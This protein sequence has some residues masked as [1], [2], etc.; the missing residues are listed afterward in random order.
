MEYADWLGYIASGL[1]AI[2]MMMS[3]ILKFRLINLAGGLCFSIY[4]FVL[5]A[6]PVGY[7]NGFIVCVN[8]YYLWTFYRKK[9]IFETLEIKHDSEYLLRFID[10]HAVDVQSIC[11]G[12]AYQPEMNSISFFI[13]RNMQVAGLFLARREGNTLT[14]GLDFVIPEYRDFKNGKFIYT[15][16]A[17]E[18]RAVGITKILAEETNKNNENYFRKIGFKKDQNG[19]YSIRL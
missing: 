5:G 19:F 6:L 16:L 13:L 14:V 15:K 17:P 11:P 9:E 3:S 18:L 2:S 7:L 8:L 10:F 12:F 4:G 1:I